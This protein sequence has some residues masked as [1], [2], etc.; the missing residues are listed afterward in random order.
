MVFYLLVHAVLIII[1]SW[2]GSRVYKSCPANTF[3]WY[4]L[5]AKIIS[6]ITFG[7]V[8]KY[9]MH[10]GDT[11]AYFESSKVLAQFFQTDPI[12]YLR[13]LVGSSS[14]IEIMDEIGFQG[15]PRAVIMVRI[16]SILTI[17]TFGNYWLCA[18]YFSLF[19][20]FG[21]WTLVD[22]ICSSYSDSIKSAI[23]AFI[24]LPSVLF[25]SSGVS[26]ETLYMGV[27]G[28]LSAWFLPFFKNS[29]GTSVLKWGIALIMVLVLVP[30][31]YYYMAV[32]LPILLTTIL[33]NRIISR[34][35]DWFI[36]YS[37]WFLIF[38]L[39][40]FAASWIHTNLTPAHFSAVVKS[41]ALEIISKT[42][43]EQLVDFR[44]YPNPLGWMV[45]NFPLAIVTGLF[46]PNIIDAGSFFQNLAILE[47]LFISVL[48]VG[49]IKYFETKDLKSPAFLPC[50]FYVVILA[51]ILTLATPNFGT[52]VRY[53]VSFL[54]VFVFFIL[55]KNPWW[56]K[57]THRLP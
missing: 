42:N 53:K 7:L 3:Y 47:N 39:L 27:F 4:G 52:L 20:F 25:W 8:Y 33:V 38:L 50:F 34:N 15:Q 48:F 10:G 1:L 21:L 26:K 23:G 43:P 51:S 56:N 9:L 19:S 24:F 28:Y 40:L 29:A 57:L 17:F 5:S 35:Q 18:I 55:Y 2:W 41:N 37:I 11:W 12:V 46:R 45:I 13:L 31:K 30:L 16:L 22:K 49:R 32:L 36:Q 54:P 14:P 44:E 6:G